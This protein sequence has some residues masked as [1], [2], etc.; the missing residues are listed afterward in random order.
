MTPR[1]AHVFGLGVTGRAVVDWLLKNGWMVIVSDDMVSES[2]EAMAAELKGSGAE[3]LLG[4]HRG[5]LGR[6]VD[7]VVLSPGIPP[8]TPAVQE[9]IRQ[10]AEVIGEIEL[11]WRSSQGTFAAVTGANG[12]STTTAL[13]GEIFRLSRR[14]T[15]TVGNIGVPLIEIADATDNNSLISLEVSSYQLETIV[16]F[17]PYVAALLN[18]TPD[19]L[20][21]HGSLEGY[22]RAKAKIWQNQTDS[23]WLVFNADDPMVVNLIQTAKSTKVPF[24]LA[25]P[26]TMGGWI[27]PVGRT[28]VRP[29]D[30]PSEFVFKLPNHDDFTIPRGLS[31]LPGRHNEANILAAVLMAKLCGISNEAVNQGVSSFKGLS[32]R[33]E[34]I[35]E[36]EG[37]T[38]INDSKATNIDAGRWALEAVK[39]PVILLAGGRPKKGGF[40]GIRHSILKKVKIIVTFGE[41]ASEIERD[42]GDLV[43]TVHVADLAAALTVARRLAVAGDTILLSPLCASFDQFQSFEQRGDVFRQLVR[44]LK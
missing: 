24:S 5:A 29:T 31:S 21:R 35:R 6:T 26:L 15:F 44:D 11:G 19:H 13:L 3:V 30:T 41:G 7:L 42:L 22:G 27:E 40:Q 18:I 37:V 25:G 1:R 34:M 12:K 39:A 38:Y 10:G 28:T 17:R 2:L 20:E 33:L 43:E 23:D 16:N 32:H 9:R 8:A 14:K 36:F 4:G